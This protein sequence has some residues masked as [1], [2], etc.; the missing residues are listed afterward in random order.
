MSDWAR[1]A[2]VRMLMRTAKQVRMCMENALAGAGSSYATFIILDA[3]SLEPGLSQRQ[4]AQRIS[5]EG[6]PLTRH[7]DRMETDG[8]VERR[9]DYLDRRIQRVYSTA[10]GSALYA[11]LC[12]VVAR[13]EHRYFEDMPARDMAGFR[14]VLGQL[15]A[16]LDVDVA[17]AKARDED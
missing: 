3:V 4:I 6:P 11:A 13:L 1:E 12:P 9:R 14:N 8:L 15:K 10:A 17:G 7:L 2:N 16:K 5:I